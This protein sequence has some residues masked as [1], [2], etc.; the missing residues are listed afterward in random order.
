MS[1]E[2]VDP[3]DITAEGLVNAI[4][5]GADMLEDWQGELAIAKR[6]LIAHTDEGISAEAAER[7]KLAAVVDSNYAE[8]QHELA[9]LATK[10]SVEATRTDSLL[11]RMGDAESAILEEAQTRADADSAMASQTRTMVASLSGDAG[12]A[13]V[14]DVLGRA[15]GADLALRQYAAIQETMDVVVKENEEAV[16]RIETTLGAAIGEN[17]A[18]IKNEQTARA[19]ADGALATSINNVVASIGNP[20]SPAPGTVYAAVRTEATARANADSALASNVTTLQTKV[21]GNTASV[22]QIMQSV[23]GIK[24]R[25]GVRLDVN[26]RVTGLELLGGA[27]QTAM[28]FKVDSF[29]IQ[30]PDN[31]NGTPPFMLGTVNGRT[32]VVIKDAFIQDAAISSAKIKT[33]AVGTLHIQDHA[34]TNTMYAERWPLS[35]ETPPGTNW[36]VDLVTRTVNVSSADTVMVHAGGVFQFSSGKYDYHGGFLLRLYAGASGEHL[37]AEVDYYKYVMK[38]GGA[39]GMPFLI[40][41]VAQR[42]SGTIYLRLNAYCWGYNQY[43]PRVTGGSFDKCWM[44]IHQ[45]RK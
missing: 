44:I 5:N 39:G 24:A 20:A 16:A 32:Q 36:N 17:Y 26:G 18:A 7:V 11:V 2:G 10:Q 40:A 35:W 9:V 22:Q 14:G 15:E 43:P 31:P 4:L 42:G 8:A 13:L 41:G 38:V 3:A 12:D 21:D 37:I 28:V 27:N 25:W 45:V 34:V 6:E 1:Q 19:N 23:D 30:T 29:I 33:L